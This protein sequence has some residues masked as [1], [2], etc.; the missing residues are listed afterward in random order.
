MLF[1][2]RLAKELGMSVERVLNEISVL[3]IRAWAEYFV[4]VHDM[5][6]EAAEKARSRR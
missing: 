3:E 4:Y 1:V 6:K 5:E 2:F